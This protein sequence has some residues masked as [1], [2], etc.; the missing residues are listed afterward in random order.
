MDSAFWVANL[1]ANLAYGDRYDTVMPLVNTGSRDPYLIQNEWEMNVNS[2]DILESFQR[3][4]AGGFDH[5]QELERL[6]QAINL[7][8]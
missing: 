4:K 3:F 6:M 5:V 8:T 2:G 1:V 7:I